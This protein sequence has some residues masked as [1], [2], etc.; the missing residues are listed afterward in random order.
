[1]RVHSWRWVLGLV[2]VVATFGPQLAPE[3]AAAPQVRTGDGLLL[4]ASE[5]DWNNLQ[6]LP[7]GTLVVIERTHGTKLKG[8]LTS[9]ADDAMSVR[10][11]RRIVGVARVEVSRVLVR[12]GRKVRTGALVSG[13]F[14]ALL[15]AV[16]NLTGAKPPDW[17]PPPGWVGSFSQWETEG[18]YIRAKVGTVLELASM[19]VGIGGA[20]GWLVRERSVV[21]RAPLGALGEPPPSAAPPAALV[22]A[23][24]VESL[25]GPL[26]E[27]SRVFSTEQAAR[28]VARELARQNRGPGGT[29]NGRQQ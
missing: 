1:M 13:G 28:E 19:G 15:A 6:R 12:G 4:L 21:Y 20:V 14:A 11:R 18:A 5:T 24:A 23:A 27:A 17:Q 2:L 8:R 7:L 22:S 25:P 3:L 16:V 9:V 10:H 29:S 26:R